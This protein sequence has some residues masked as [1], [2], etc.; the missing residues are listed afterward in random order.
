VGEA[1]YW[2]PEA[3]RLLLNALNADG[4]PTVLEDMALE[5]MVL[6]DMASNAPG[7]LLSADVNGWLTRGTTGWTGD[8]VGSIGRA[9]VV[10]KSQGPWAGFASFASSPLFSSAACKSRVI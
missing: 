4:C 9:L 5:D 6:E 8:A 10:R 2:F 1:R 3:A 7:I